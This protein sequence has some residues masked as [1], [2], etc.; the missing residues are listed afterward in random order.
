MY[1]TKDSSRNICVTNVVCTSQ[2]IPHSCQ[3]TG[4]VTILTRRLPLVEQELLT[5]PEHMSLPP[6]NSGVRISRCLD[7]Y[8]CFVDSFCVFV[9]FPLAIVF[10]VLLQYMHIDSDY[11]FGIFRCFLT[12]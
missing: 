8:V 2:S 6:V 10:S 1:I 11:P 4:F 7:L 3:T 9:L 5:L 12:L